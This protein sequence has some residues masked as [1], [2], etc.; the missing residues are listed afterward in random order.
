MGLNRPNE[1]EKKLNRDIWDMVHLNKKKEHFLI[2]GLKKYVL[3]KHKKYSGDLTDQGMTA[4]W[5]Q[6]FALDLEAK[7]LWRH[8]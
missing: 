7:D 3:V 1:I 4:D 2:S 5:N 8:Q 6:C